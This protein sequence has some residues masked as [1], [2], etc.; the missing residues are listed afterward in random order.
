MS[1]PHASN[2]KMKIVVELR[3][4]VGVRGSMEKCQAAEQT[5]LCLPNHAPCHSDP[6][7]VCALGG[8][9][10]WELQDKSWRMQT[11]RSPGAW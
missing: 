10:G 11:A 6:T 4:A 1:I 7:K 9:V 5:G 2:Q 3:G 8:E